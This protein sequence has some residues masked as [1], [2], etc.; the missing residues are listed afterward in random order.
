MRSACACRAPLRCEALVLCSHSFGA[1]VAWTLAMRLATSGFDIRAVVSMDFRNVRTKSIGEVHEVPC[2]PRSL[3]QSLAAEHVRLALVDV[4]FV[5]PLVPRGR[6]HPRFLRRKD[7]VAPWQSSRLSLCWTR[8][9]AETDHF[10]LPSSHSW[11]VQRCLQQCCARRRRC[12]KRRPRVEGSGL[13]GL[14]P[15][16]AHAPHVPAGPGLCTCCKF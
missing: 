5:A 4:D 2:V 14:W 16:H 9:L 1:A 15:T 7:A 10:D 13:I 12:K 8:Q 6:L 11:D 3:L